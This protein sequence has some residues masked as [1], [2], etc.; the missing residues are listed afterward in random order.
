MDACCAE[1]AA[2]LHYGAGCTE[3]AT[4]HPVYR[5]EAQGAGKPQHLVLT[6]CAPLSLSN[7]LKYDW[8]WFLSHVFFSAGYHPRAAEH[9]VRLCGHVPG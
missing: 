9:V 1:L 7:E 5:R 4:E 8:A 2:S 6:M 3:A